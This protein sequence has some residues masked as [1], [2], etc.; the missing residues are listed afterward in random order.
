MAYKYKFS[1]T[2]SKV[3]REGGSTAIAAAA[4]TVAIQQTVGFDDPA[5]STVWMTLYT[6]VIGG[7]LKGGRNLWTELIMPVL[8]RKFIGD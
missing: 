3:G 7:A 1:T 2:A 4:A 8:K 5:M 6:G